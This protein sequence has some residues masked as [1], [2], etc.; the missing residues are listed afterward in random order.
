MFKDGRLI[1]LG[2]NELTD[3][4]YTNRVECPRFNTPPFKL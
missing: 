2:L 1:K 3:V 4:L